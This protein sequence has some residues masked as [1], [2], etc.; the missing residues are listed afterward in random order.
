MN[1]AIA[2][3]ELKYSSRVSQHLPLSHPHEAENG[4]ANESGT[5]A[6][7]RQMSGPRSFGTSR[8]IS[9]GRLACVARPIRGRSSLWQKMVL[10][11]RS[12]SLLRVPDPVA[13]SNRLV[14]PVKSPAC[15]QPSRLSPSSGQPSH[16][17]TDPIILP[18]AAVTPPFPSQLVLSALCGML[19]DLHRNR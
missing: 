14:S 16:T 18:N 3:V 19:R 2:A 12:I 13:T 9:L 11:N 8:V 6:N 4:F 5:N 17:S 15:M 1:G 7:A 10:F